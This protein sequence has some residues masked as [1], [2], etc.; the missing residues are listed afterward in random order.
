MSPLT[1]FSLEELLNLQVTTVSKTAENQLDAAA[2]IYVISQEDIRRSGV[3]SVAE[4]LRLSPGLHVARIDSNKWAISARGFNDRFGNKL[5]VMIDGRSVYTTMFSGVYWD[6]QDLILDDIDRIEIIR[7][8]GAAL[9]GANAV[10]GVINII[11]KKTA[12]T[13]GGLLS[14]L[15]GTEDQNITQFRY[16][17]P[18]G[19]EA[20]Y[21]LYGKFF[22]RDHFSTRNGDNADDEWSG[23][24]AGFRMDWTPSSQDAVMFQGNLY[25]GESKTAEQLPFSTPPYLDHFLGDDDYYGGYILANWERQLYDESNI[26]LQT[27]YDHDR[28]DNAYADITRHIFDIDFQHN[29]PLSDWQEFSWGLGYRLTADDIDDT[30]R[31]MASPAS[32]N[33]QLLNAF[34]QDKIELIEDELTLTLGSKFEHND[35][36]GFE[37]QPS[38]RLLWSPNEQHRLWGA[39][40][41]AVRTPSR[42]EHDIRFPILATPPSSERNPLPIPVVAYVQGDEDFDAEDLLA[43][44][45]GYRYLFSQKL[46]FDAAVFYNQYTGLRSGTPD[47]LTLSDDGLYGVAPILADN[48][49]DG[50][51]YGAEIAVDYAPVEWWAWAL[52]Y[53]W[54]DIQLHLPSDNPIVDV[55]SDENGTPRHQA[56]LR[57]S[58]DI[59]EEID[60]DLWLR[61]TD[62]LPT[63]DVP[64]YFSLDA[65]L[66]WS[67]G[68]NFEFVLGGQNLLNDSHVEFTRSNFFAAFPSEVDRQ[69]YAKVT[70]TF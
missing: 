14:V 45:I 11:T 41:R 39:I 55:L 34:L 50:E 61:Y 24:R 48:D 32:R 21:R 3:T 25:T 44:E 65:R 9:W 4:A 6:M 63:Y 35:Y 10:N 5:L 47:V 18:L 8:P 37:I 57:S 19:S 15:V 43:F 1:Q 69:V 56:S 36:S 23:G 58:L 54:I 67:P 64:S 70:W 17:A 42:F 13:R 52:T 12:D 46:T 51:T 26:S 2:A 68:D 40:S 59:G 53:T 30:I 16:G 62:K 22:D 31:Y 49:M 7:G 29:F 20:D 66:S 60:F 28:R 38:G 27:Y 33:D